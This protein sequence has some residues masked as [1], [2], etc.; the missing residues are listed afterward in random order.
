MSKTY[1]IWIG[2]DSRDTAE[3][4]DDAYDAE[5][6][7]R[8]MA[9]ALASA[10]GIDHDTLD[11]YGS[12]AE[13]LDPSGNGWGVCPGGNDGGYWPVIRVEQD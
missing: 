13:T 3:R 8:E 5:E 9:E 10:E 2:G 7:A 4:R 12:E 6:C 1:S 11:V